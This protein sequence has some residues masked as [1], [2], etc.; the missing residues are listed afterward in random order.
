MVG[1]VLVVGVVL[2]VVVVVSVVVADVVRLVV[3]VSEVVGDVVGEVVGVV[4]LHAS[5][6]PSIEDRTAAFTLAATIGHVSSVANRYPLP[7][8]R[9]VPSTTGA[10]AKLAASVFT[11]AANRVQDCRSPSTT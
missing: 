5:N 11:A 6:G 10:D 8:H 2:G 7:V 4:C 1:V 3:V 9:T